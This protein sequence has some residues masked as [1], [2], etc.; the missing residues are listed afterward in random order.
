MDEN[1][2]TITPVIIAIRIK[3]LSERHQNPR[4]NFQVLDI[5]FRELTFSEATT[6]GINA[7]K[8]DENTKTNTNRSISSMITKIGLHNVITKLKVHAR[9][10]KALNSKAVRIKARSSIQY[11]DAANLIAFP[12]GI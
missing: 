2:R 6:Q 1:I 7:M 12:K 9:H 3:M 11:F 4:N 8:T 5:D 10:D